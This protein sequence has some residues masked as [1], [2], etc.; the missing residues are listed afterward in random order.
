[1]WKQEMED[2]E[3]IYVFGTTLKKVLSFGHHYCVKFDQEEVFVQL[4]VTPTFLY[5]NPL[6]DGAE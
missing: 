1:M 4:L 2:S 6:K 5:F 3:A